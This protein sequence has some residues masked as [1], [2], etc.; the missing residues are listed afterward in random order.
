MSKEQQEKCQDILRKT[1]IELDK[2]SN[3][4]TFKHVNISNVLSVMDNAV[5]YMGAEIKDIDSLNG[6][7][8]LT[9][10]INR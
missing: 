1:V 6:K 10:T 5:F 4:S 8:E 2:I 3:E 9:S 7:W